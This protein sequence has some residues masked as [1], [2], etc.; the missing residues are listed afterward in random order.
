VV[1]R[2]S[3]VTDQDITTGIASLMGLASYL[4]RLLSEQKLWTLER[5]FYLLV[6]Y[7]ACAWNARVL[8]ARVF[9]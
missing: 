1:D 3:P 7:T 6:A 5:W 8:A 2:S 4:W 9:H